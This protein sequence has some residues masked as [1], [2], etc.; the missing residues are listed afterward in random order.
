MTKRNAFYFTFGT[1]EKYP[2]QGGWVKVFASSKAE[3]IITFRKHYPNRA[4]SNCYNACD[5]YASDY[6]ENTNMFKNGNLGAF[7]HKVLYDE[8][9]NNYEVMYMAK[10]IDG[11]CEKIN[12]ML[13]TVIENSG[14]KLKK[15]ELWEQKQGYETI[16]QYANLY[17]EID[18]YGM[19]E[20]DQKL[21]AQAD[22]NN[23]L[24][25]RLE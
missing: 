3:A 17:I 14:G 5:C 24:V 4:N 9:A 18:G 16:A 22:V 19:K 15:V 1:D 13:T 6:F 25:L 20:I 2:F 12:A 21:K 23:H 11:I 10:P 7:C 8:K